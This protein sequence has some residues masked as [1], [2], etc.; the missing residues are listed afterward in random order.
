LA[1]YSNAYEKTVERISKEIRFE[2]VT[3]ANARYYY[4]KNEFEKA[5]P[6]LM[7]ILRNNPDRLITIKVYALEYRYKAA[8]GALDMLGRIYLKNGSIKYALAC[9]DEM[10][11]R[12][13]NDRFLG[14]FTS[15]SSQNYGG[16]AGAE[17][18]CY[19]MWIFSNNFS[20]YGDCMIDNTPD[21]EKSISI[22]KLLIKNFDGVTRRCYGDCVNYEEPAADN[23]V[24]C[25]I[26][27]KASIGRM[28]NE[29]RWIIKNTKNRVLCA[30]LLLE[31]GELYHSQNND[32]RALRIF[33][34]VTREYDDAYYFYAADNVARFYP[35]EAFG[36]MLAILTEKNKTNE[37]ER[38]KGDIAV[39]YYEFRQEIERMHK[40]QRD[41]SGVTRKHLND[42][43][44]EYIYKYIDLNVGGNRKKR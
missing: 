9:F 35:L 24:Y 41:Y 4:L 28:E 18:L 13:K 10:F 42:A 6:L 1:V 30:S 36:G 5:T 38:L 21:Y 27:E 8:P 32:E 33:G 2:D 20:G 26:S 7:K 29:I 12:Y 23:I 43:M 22:S 3:Y 11:T 37:I 34:E 40:N 14:A 31:L 19:E 16:P 17:A 44:D 39:T 25:L 15:L